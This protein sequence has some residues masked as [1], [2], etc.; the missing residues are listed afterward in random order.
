MRE[1]KDANKK[2]P[3]PEE[4]PQGGSRH[5]RRRLAAA[6]HGKGTQD[7]S[8]TRLYPAMTAPRRLIVGISGAS[9]V[10][11]GLRPVQALRATDIQTHLV[12]TQPAQMTL[13]YHDARELADVP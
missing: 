4:R 13:A 12:V 2:L 10:V 8:A 11:Y 7:A 1:T 5:S 6:P 3:H 9:G